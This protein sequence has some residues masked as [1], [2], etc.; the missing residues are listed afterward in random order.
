MYIRSLQSMDTDLQMECSQI[1]ETP[2]SHS[3]ID[4]VSTGWNNISHNT[5]AN[6]GACLQQ[7]TEKF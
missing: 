2:K 5:T 7:I 4:S 1:I 6:T 3:F